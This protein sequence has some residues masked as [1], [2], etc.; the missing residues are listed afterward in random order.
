MRNYTFQGHEVTPEEMA[1]LVL[2]QADEHQWMDD[3]LPEAD[4]KSLPFN[5]SDISALRRAR[6]KVG[7]DLPYLMCSVPS[8]DDFPGWRDLAELHRDL[9]RSRAID[10]D[11][12]LGAV[13][14]LK[15][16]TF[17]TFEGAKS[18]I[19]FLDAR[20]FGNAARISTLPYLKLYLFCVFLF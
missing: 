16:S 15:D 13:L 4:H 3:D 20:P 10:A 18:L 11:L 7:K 17:E 8:A 14:N 12:V 9:G 5:D 1:K 19:A 2:A 6:L